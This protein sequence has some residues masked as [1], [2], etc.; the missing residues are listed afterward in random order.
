MKRDIQNA[1]DVSL[2][3]NTFYSKVNSDDLLSPVF[4]KEAHTDWE[5]HLPKMVRFWSSILLDS[6][7]YRG[8]PFDQHAKHANH[9]TGAHFDRWLMLFEETLNELFEGEK[10]DL[11]LQ[12]AKSIG[13]IF[14]YKLDF[15]RNNPQ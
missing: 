2:L 12:R 11:A 10:K 7:E 5:T 14:Q 13:S 4:N 3:V 15:I 6:N 9:I 1:E 8:Q